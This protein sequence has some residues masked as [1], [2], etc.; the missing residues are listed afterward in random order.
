M[1][2]E[3]LQKLMADGRYQVPAEKVAE[4]IIV[5]INPTVLERVPPAGDVPR[6]P[7]PSRPPLRL[8]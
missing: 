2:L 1:D 5:W 4:A 3:R 8:L 7:R 6:Q